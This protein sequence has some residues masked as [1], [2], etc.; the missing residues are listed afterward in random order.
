MPKVSVRRILVTVLLVVAVPL[1]LLWAGVAI[2]G[3]GSRADTST[4]ALGHT[5]LTGEVERMLDRHQAMMEQMRVNATPEML[6]MMDS[7]PMWRAM[8]T[9]EFAELMEEHQRQIDRMLGDGG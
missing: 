2:F 5:V 3:D 9:G 4:T 1:G 8:R 7:D 6:A